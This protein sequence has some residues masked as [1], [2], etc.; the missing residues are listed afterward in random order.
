MN[1]ILFNKLIKANV[2]FSVLSCRNNL[3]GFAD[4]SDIE[5]YVITTKD[6]KNKL[7]GLRFT[8]CDD[9]DYKKT[10]YERELNQLEITDFKNNLKEFDLV[11]SFNEGKVYEFKGTSVKSEYD[12]IIKKKEKTTQTL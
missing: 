9:D 10:I 6:Y 11:K 2:P 7:K 4:L 3:K 1:T 12:K 5:Y 8:K